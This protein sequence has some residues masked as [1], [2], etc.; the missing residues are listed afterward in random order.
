VR[1]G[2]S[3]A[4][5]AEVPA[6]LKAGDERVALQGRWLQNHPWPMLPQVYD[7]STTS[8]LMERLTDPPYAMVNHRAFLSRVY[9]ALQ[10]LW[11]RPPAVQFSPD[12]HHEK[13][14]SLPLGVQQIHVLNDLRVLSDRINWRG[15]GVGLSHGD[16]TL[17]NVMLR[18]SQVVLIDPI[19]ATPAVPD[20]WAVDTGKLLQSVLGYELLRYSD[21][22]YEWRID[23]LNLRQLVDNDNEW[24]A[25]VYW[26]VVHLLRALP[27]MPNEDV[28]AGI[29]GMIK[30]AFDLV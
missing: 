28:V 24:I 17:D 30:N 18:G 2:S 9:D 27:Y 12:A 5:I 1:R 10:T 13:L 7:V 20:L 8:Y 4:E 25:T 23:P 29:W 22:T 6:V 15:L 14:N 3:G 26:C 21:P 16:P 19:P 11:W